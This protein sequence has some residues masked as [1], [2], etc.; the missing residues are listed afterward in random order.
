M[1]NVLIGY[2]KHLALRAAVPALAAALWAALPPGTLAQES[3]DHLGDLVEEALA[4]HPEIDAA[5]SRVEAASARVPQVG[6][7]PDPTLSGGLM[8]VPL[9]E[10]S[11]SG[12][13][14]TM[15][16]LQLSQRLPPRGLRAARERAAEAELEV[17][18]AEVDLAGWSITTRLQEAYFELLLVAHAEEVH[19]RTYATLEA[20]EASAAAAYGQG[21]VPQRDILRAQTELAGLA[22]HMAELRQRRGVAEAEVNAFLGRD[23]RAPIRPVV[24]ERLTALLEAEPG[25]GLLTEHLMHAELGGGMPTL[26]EL[27][28]RALEDRPEL[29]LSGHRLSAARHKAEAARRDRNPGVAITGSYAFRSSRADMLSAGVSVE[30][31]LFRSRKQD[32]A[33]V[34]AEGTAEA[35]RSDRDGLIREIRRQVAEAHA[36]LVR[37][38]ERAILLEEGVIPQARATVESAAAAYRAGEG[39]F[40]SLMEVFAVLFRSEIEHAHLTAEVGQTLARLERAVGSEIPWENR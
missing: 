28:E 33:V 5:R 13:G 4:T 7:L 1:K 22:E 19:H 34:E 20:F 37:A 27:Q 12:E 17:A 3:A 16:S 15:F 9:P 26:T 30:L 35:I 40:T 18:R 8:N 14:M 38:R 10:V 23:T 24:P 36:D 31:P 2:A 32:Q 29:A 25:P 21:M 39:D 11:L 6:A